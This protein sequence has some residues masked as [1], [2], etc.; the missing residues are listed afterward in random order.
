MS[1][2]ESVSC[3]EFDEDTTD[4]PHVTGETPTASENDFG[5]AIVTCTYQVRMVLVVESGTAEIDQTHFCVSKDFF[6]SVT[7]LMYQ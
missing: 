7:T 4:G 2:E 5:C 1:L 3:A 6:G